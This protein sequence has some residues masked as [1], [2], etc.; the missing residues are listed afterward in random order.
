MEQQS[1]K[2]VLEFENTTPVS[3]HFHIC[4]FC[5]P[6]VPQYLQ[7]RLTNNSRAVHI[8]EW[9]LVLLGLSGQS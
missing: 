8:N 2:P 6:C 7:Q 4:V 9:V 1:L 3:S 5:S